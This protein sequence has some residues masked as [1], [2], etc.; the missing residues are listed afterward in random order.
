MDDDHLRP[1]DGPPGQSTSHGPSLPSIELSDLSSQEAVSSA[2]S[3][4]PTN[5]PPSTPA[6]SLRPSFNSS[7]DPSLSRLASSG[8]TPSLPVVDEN[9]EGNQAQ[10][11]SSVPGEEASPPF[12]RTDGGLNSFPTLLQALQIAR[13]IPGRF[14]STSWRSLSNWDSFQTFMGLFV[15][16]LAVITFVFSYRSYELAK[17][18]R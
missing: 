8:Q 13:Q 3:V 4:S 1:P 14:C 18:E 6:T 17:W 12:R 10:S 15:S 16:V 9:Q 5:T 7:E 11:R 2:S